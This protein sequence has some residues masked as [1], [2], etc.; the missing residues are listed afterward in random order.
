MTRSARA[1]LV[2][3]SAAVLVL[4]GAAFASPAATPTSG[5][6]GGAVGAVGTAPLPTALPAAARA[7][8]PVRAPVR[9][10]AVRIDAI[11]AS[12]SLVPLG[13]NSD[14]SV[15]VP[16]LSTPEQAGYYRFG[17]LP[18]DAGPSVILG[19][20]NG[21]GRPGVFSRLAEVR[22]GDRVTV[23]RAGRTYGFV[24]TRVI[25]VDKD[26]FPTRDVYG[27]TAGPELRLITCGGRL[28]AAA[29][30][31]LDQVIVFATP[32]R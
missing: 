31:Y 8:A 25:S 16:S 28:D 6:A 17:P 18:G 11:G 22:P 19:H 4:T 12:S 1:V 27:N 9:D 7:A 13:V 32:A 23:E 29:G 21:D 14:R 26:A 2:L 30:R 15:E 5:P 20:V 3:L 10:L 24:V